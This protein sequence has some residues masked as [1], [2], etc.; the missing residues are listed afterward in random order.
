MVNEALDCQATVFFNFLM[1][2]MDSDS[3]NDLIQ[4][5]FRIILE[6]VRRMAC[7]S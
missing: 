7:I 3:G 5:V 1:D 6:S 4:P 2:L